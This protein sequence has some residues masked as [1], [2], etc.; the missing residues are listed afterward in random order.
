[1]RIDPPPRDAQPALWKYLAETAVLGKRENVPP[2]LAGEWLRSILARTR[3]PQTLRATILMRLR[4][5]GDVSVLRV[6]MLKAVLIRNFNQ[7][8]PV[9]LD[10]DNRDK[11]YLL[12]RLFVVY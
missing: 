8:A 3:Y 2:N 6:S 9:A 4:A 1:M 5:N 10:P 12:G 11:G 7:E